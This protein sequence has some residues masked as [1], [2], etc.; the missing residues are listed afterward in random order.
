MK[1]EEPWTSPQTAKITGFT[2]NG[3]PVEEI[4][5]FTINGVP[6]EVGQFVVKDSAGQL[7]ARTELQAGDEP[8]FV[9]GEQKWN[10]DGNTFVTFH[11]E[12][13]IYNGEEAFP[14][15]GGQMTARKRK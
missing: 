3:V 13:G 14:W 6:V 5:G 8:C 2:I 7:Q 1:T 4:T 15:Q 12:P 11:E 10:E 9:A